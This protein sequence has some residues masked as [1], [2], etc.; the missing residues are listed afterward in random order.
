VDNFQIS[1]SEA[2]AEK[3]KAA[4]LEEAKEHIFDKLK[5]SFDETVDG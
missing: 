4:E 5:L 1:L 3:K 2:E